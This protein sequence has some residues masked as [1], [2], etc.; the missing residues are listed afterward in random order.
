V[1]IMSTKKKIDLDREV[2]I[3]KSGKRIT[4]TVADQIVADVQRQAAGRGRPS[5]TG[6]KH[7]SPRINLRVPDELHETLEAAAKYAGVTLSVLVREI[8]EHVASSAKR[9][10]AEARRINDKVAS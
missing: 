3:G 6:A 1:D 5:L 10:E 4:Q 2:V 8:L 7:V 9:L